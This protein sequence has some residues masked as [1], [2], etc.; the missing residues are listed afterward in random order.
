MYC[1][2]N[3]EFIRCVKPVDDVGDPM[4][5]M[6]SDASR[7]V[8]GTCAYVRWKLQDKRVSCG[9]LAAKYRIPPTR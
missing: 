6:L 9:L 4:L 8:Y 3:V 2:V 1:L 7:D 5:V